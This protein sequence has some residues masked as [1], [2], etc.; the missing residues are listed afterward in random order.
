[1]IID[2]DIINRIKKE[3]G[4]LKTE[5]TEKLVANKRVKIENIDLNWN[6]EIA[7]LI[8]TITESSTKI[9]KVQIRINLDNGGMLYGHYC[10]CNPYSYKSCEHI[11]AVLLE[12]DSNPKYIAKI[13]EIIEDE[14]KAQ[15]RSMFNTIIEKFKYS[16]DD[17]AETDFV[18]ETTN[19]SLINNNIDIVPV[20]KQNRY[21]EYELSFKIGENKMYKLKNLEE[22]YKNFSNNNLYKYGEH[23]VF[24]HTE[25]AFLKQ[26]KPFLDFILKYGQAIYFGNAMLENKNAYNVHKI[27]ASSLLL[28]EKVLDDFFEILKN[29]P[30][31]I[32][33]EGKKTSLNFIKG[34][35]DIKFYL[36]KTSDEEYKLSVSSSELK[37]LQGLNKIYT[38]SGNNV[39]EYDKNKYKDVFRLLS[40]FKTRAKSEFNFEKEELVGFV[41][42][43]LPKIRDNVSF[44]NLP[45]EVVEKYIPKKLA[46]K[47]YLDLTEKGDILATLNFCYEDIEFEPFSNKIPAIPRDM[48]AE[49]RVLQRFIMDGFSYSKNYES[50]LMS[51][52]EQIYNF[53]INNITYYMESYEVL[54]SEDFKK[55]EIKRP[56]LT[57]LGVKIQNN[58]LNIDLSGLD[59]DPKELKTILD[60]YK[61]K[62]KYHRLKN[63]E[64]LSLEENEDLDFIENLTEGMEVDYASLSK[65]K[66]KIPVNRSLYLNKLLD[67]VKN[68]EINEDKAFREIITNTENGKIDEEIVIPKELEATLRTYQKTGYKWLKVLD[69]YKFGGILADDMGL[70]KNVTINCSYI[71]GKR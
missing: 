42:N 60:K 54:I 44:E 28:T 18:D 55:R 59:F 46:V 34:E 10:E 19:V 38:I 3:I 67:N 63:G 43:V 68:L 11:L 9:Y 70:R 61:L 65:G 7:T 39:Y 12:F 25:E 16:E 2:E 41:N 27:P 6:F 13:H 58:L 26:A 50:F 1:M 62:K 49:K 45:E 36:D 21:S 35:G 56:K 22:F 48:A 24:K 66:I 71:R 47:V 52:E 17:L 53:I 15:E 69:K 40:M 57:T 31:L 37:I 29:K 32:E 30:Y 5:K 23:L 20:L 8:A 14:R 4:R 64:F 51:N 33:L